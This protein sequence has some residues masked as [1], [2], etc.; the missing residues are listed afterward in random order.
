VDEGKIIAGIK[1]DYRYI[2]VKKLRNIC[3]T[4]LENLDLSNALWEGSRMKK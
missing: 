1:I 4:T 3:R 2:V